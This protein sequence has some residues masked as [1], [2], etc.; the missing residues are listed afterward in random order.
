[1]QKGNMSFAKFAAAGPEP[2]IVHN[3]NLNAGSAQ[4]LEMT[5]QA[6]HSG[7]VAVPHLN[8]AAAPP[9]TAKHKKLVELAQRGS[10]DICDS[11]TNGVHARKA[12]PHRSGDAVQDGAEMPAGSDDM[13]TQV[14]SSN[15]SNKP[16]SIDGKSVTSGTT[17]ALDEKESLRPDDS[18]SVKAVEDDDAFSVQGNGLTGSRFGSDDGVRAFRDQL[19]EISSMEPSRRTGPPPPFGN[20]SKG[21]LYVPPQ[22]PG[23][24][25]VPNVSRSPPDGSPVA[26][27]PPDQKLLDALDNPRDRVWVLKLEQDVIDFVKDAKEASLTLPQ[28][29]AF[30]R[31]L[32]H[33]MAD[34]YMLGHL[35]D[36]TTSAVRLYKTPDCRIPPPLTG[37][38][39]PSTAASTPP[40]SGPKMTILQRG[41]G[42]A[43]ANGSNMLSK[44]GS[45]NGDSEDD[46]KKAPVTREQ[47]E[48][49]YEAARLRIMGSAKPSDAS[50]LPKDSQESRSSSIAGRKHRR[51]QRADSDDGFEARSAYSN[52]YAPSFPSEGLSTQYAPFPEYADV[53]SG[54]YPSPYHHQG[55][56]GPPQHVAMQTPGNPAWSQQQ[57][58]SVEST[59]AWA[60]GQSGA[61]DLSA[62]FQRMSFHGQVPPQVQNSNAGPHY[63]QHFYGAQAGWPPQP[64]HHPQPPPPPPPPQ[65]QQYQMQGPPPPPNHTYGPSFM[66]SA[67]PTHDPYQSYPFGELPSQTFSGRPASFSEHPL[68]GSYK[69]KHFNPQSQ[70]FI[71][72]QA[73]GRPF[74]P[75][76][77]PYAPNSAFGTS[78]A[79][80]SQLQRQSS[81]HSPS[82]G[83]GSP[84]NN[85]PHMT[86]SRMHVQPLTHPLPQGPVFPRQPS[87]NVPLPPKPTVN[88]QRALEH[89]GA[90]TAPGAQTTHMHGQSLLAKWGAPPS[91]PAKPPPPVEA[92]DGTRSAH[93]QRQPF[94]VAAAARQPGGYS[95]Y[96]PS[97]AQIV[98]GTGRALGG[99]EEF[100]K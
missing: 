66:P 9:P 76:R 18:A 42:P 60:Q 93:V 47:R 8:G 90:A 100:R 65:A 92:F 23:I 27:C 35:V 86:Q 25:A 41:S 88:S 13:V 94:N 80:P 19:R 67:G 30:Y 52:Y 15:G 57:Y 12:S 53:S 70:S 21:M 45:E 6:P 10:K 74:S 62:D 98:N 69:S 89:G 78:Y 22:G 58:Q 73:D 46:R 29:H 77:T 95:P 43:I 48:A 72:G 32:A 24:G 61:Y 3:P 82:S 68:P 5:P 96:G 16:P 31:L 84:H 59:Q 37:I 64:P 4:E 34:Y 1:M 55:H 81:N 99:Y 20:A 75:H 26:D 85:S 83:F 97:S 40:P 63:T 56:A 38:T 91:L 7:I 51:K 28:C 49:R 11:N 14:S 79:P 44:S 50:E 17:F 33:K 2:S 39:A 54:Q 36:D 87:P 71:P